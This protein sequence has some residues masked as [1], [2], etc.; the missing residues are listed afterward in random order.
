MIVE[1]KFYKMNLFF[2]MGLSVTY[3]I[4]TLMLISFA[5]D[6]DTNELNASLALGKDVEIA[7]IISRYNMLIES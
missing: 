2:V 4:F 5:V 7:S 6:G 1:M 3:S